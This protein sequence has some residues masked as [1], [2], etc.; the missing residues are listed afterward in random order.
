MLTYALPKPLSSDTVGVQYTTCF[1]L[2]GGFWQEDGPPAEPRST[3]PESVF[4]VGTWCL[5]AAGPQ[6]PQSGIQSGGRAQL[7]S[8]RQ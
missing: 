5:P 6:N 8:S 2:D 7:G 3:A 4:T 1:S